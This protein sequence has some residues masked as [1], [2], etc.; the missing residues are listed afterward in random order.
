MSATGDTTSADGAGPGIPR[1]REAVVRRAVDAVRDGPGVL[2]RGIQGIGRSAVIDAV[3]RELASTGHTVVTAGS[4]TASAAPFAAFEGDLGPDLPTTVDARSLAAVG[5][6]LAGRGSEEHPLVIVVDDIDD[7]D[8][9][10]AAAVHQVVAA[11]SARLVAS[12][13][14]G[15]SDR[16]GAPAPRW[17]DVATTIELEPLDRADADLVVEAL[18]GGPVDA[19]SLEWVWAAARGH[20]GWIT[21]LD[22]ATAAAGLWE[23]RAGLWRLS[24]DEAVVS[25]GALV[26]RLDGLDLEVRVVLEALALVGSI[27]IDAAEALGGATPL[28]A[29]ERAGLVRTE[30]GVG[31][32]LW[33]AVPSRI[34]AAA[35]RA[36]LSPGTEVERWDRAVRAIES[37]PRPVP[38]TVLARGRALVGAGR[39]G[40]EATDD[41]LDAV[42]AGAAAAYTLS[43]WHDSVTLAGAVWRVRRDAPSLASLTVALGMLSDHRAIRSLSDEVYEVEA[44][45]GSL[46]QHA[47]T[48]AISQFHSDDREGAFATTERARRASGPAAHGPLDVFESRLRSFGGDQES[49][50]SLVTPWCEATDP[51]L[52]SEA[53]TVRAS[54]AALRGEGVEAL[55][56]FDE[57]FAVA[58]TLPD[59]PVSLAGT[60]YLFGLS[61]RA[62][63]GRLTEA[64]SGAEAVHDEAVGRGDASV[65]GWLTLHLGRC[66]LLAGQPRAAA[67]MF[68]QSVNDLRPLHRPGW[69]GYPA[70]GLVAA[71]AAAGDLPAASTARADWAEIP[72]HAVALFRPEELRLVA[73]SDAAEGRQDEARERLTE[74]VELARVVGSVPYEV[75]ALHDLVRLDPGDGRLWAAEALVELAVRAP[76]PLIHAHA[77]HAAALV[78]GAGEALSRVAA[79]YQEMGFLLD[80]RETWTEVGR[81]AEDERGAS[82]GRRRAAALA[83]ET[84]GLRTP[85][86]G[87]GSEHPFL[88]GR[89]REVADLVAGG[90][91]RQEVA[92]RLVVSVRTVDSHLQRVY[93]KLGVRDRDA[94]AESLDD[95]G[96][97]P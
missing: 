45:D 51:E 7:L 61:A 84:E 39:V 55:A 75:A 24:R 25:D 90:A 6:A 94:L 9:P 1:G 49:A 56:G 23:P 22:E 92:D 63:C 36:R 46:A 31:G 95:V 5:D 88:T 72:P 78:A 19:R 68:A 70:A 64:I 14:R 15:G 26:A 38:A 42:L 17:D 44:V 43:R 33:C 28:V 65:Q 93:R 47:M 34:V 37:S 69:V 54:V 4:A 21:A 52:R 97:P 89:E 12:A 67:Q 80:A 32:D 86:L 50:L 40:P 73:W 2:V 48:I 60:P 96:P 30:E 20:P 87:E 11:G 83:V 8:F 71:H 13:T 57:A 10:A 81:C 58:V 62:D 3:R 82:Q 16:A 59:A 27:P 74:A 77:A 79:D 66:R 18:R 53:I 41:D 91:S 35:L 29:A 76:N 85:L